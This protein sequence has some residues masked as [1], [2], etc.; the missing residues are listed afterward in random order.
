MRQLVGVK[1]IYRILPQTP[2]INGLL[3]AV[4]LALVHLNLV[5]GMYQTHPS[6]LCTKLIKQNP[7]LQDDQHKENSIQYEGYEPLTGCV[8]LDILIALILSC[9]LVK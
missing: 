9:L 2:D 4:V 7:L 8:Y 6:S 5:L 1:Y 3:P